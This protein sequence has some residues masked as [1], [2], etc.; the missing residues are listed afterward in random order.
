MSEVSHFG[1]R[2]NASQLRGD[3]SAEELESGTHGANRVREESGIIA[4]RASSI[5]N[6]R[7]KRLS[8]QEVGMHDMILRLEVLRRVFP[9]W[10][11]SRRRIESDNQ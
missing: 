7:S 8:M 9:E 6:I 11:R 3:T 10:L 1:M 5:G 2:A 4:V